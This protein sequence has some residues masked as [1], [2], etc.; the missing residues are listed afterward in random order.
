M[1]PSSQAIFF[2]TAFDTFH[3]VRQNDRTTSPWTAAE[4]S[5]IRSNASTRQ[6]P[7]YH[8]FGREQRLPVD[9]LCRADDEDQAA[10]GDGPTT[11]KVNP[12]LRRGPF[13]TT[14]S[15]R[16]VITHKKSYK[17]SVCLPWQP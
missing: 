7:Y 15:A 1:A 14:S 4:H 2:M 10:V 17:R 6:C 3:Q 8:M 5:T 16:K 11:Y 13:P 12:K 9:L